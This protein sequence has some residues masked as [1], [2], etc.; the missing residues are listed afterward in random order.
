MSSTPSFDEL[1]LR[2]ELLRAVAEAGYTTPTPIQSQAIPTILQGL[3]VMGGAQTGTG[4]TAGFALPILQKLLP[5]ANASPSPAR[6]PVR[7]LIL[8]PTRELA[9]Q[10][11]EA[12]KTYGKYTGIRSTVVYGGVDIRQQLPIVRAGIEILVATPG[13]LLDHIEQK[14]VNLSQVEIFVLDEADRM[15]DMGFIPDI[16]RIMALLPATAKRQ[17]LLFSATF[18]NEIKKLAD[19]LLNAPTLI[20]VALR[21]TAAETVAQSVYKL[22]SD[23]KRALLTHIVTSRNLWQVLCFVRTKHGASRLARQLEKDGLKTTAIHGDKSQ[24]ARLEALDDF[25]A[26]KVQVMVATDVAARGLD[27]DDLPLVVNYEMPYVPEDYIHRIGRTGR[28]GAVGQAISLCAPDEEKLLAEIERMLKRTIPVAALDGFSPPR[29]APSAQRTTQRP[30][31]EVRETRGTKRAPHAATAGSHSNAHAAHSDSHAP[32]R[33]RAA[34]ADDRN[35]DQAPVSRAP[36]RTGAPSAPVLT[37][38]AG[39]PSLHRKHPI[40]ALLMKRS[41]REPE[42]V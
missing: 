26:A 35:P 39:R 29:D 10:V 1:G 36:N 20:E 31:R 14:S 4:K 30:T 18:S 27:I 17:N 12:V 41:V 16:K 7:A 24:A 19:Q 11:E 5:L 33:G 23:Q 28:A 22:A 40:P 3:D 34:D 37:G 9:I 38:T 32:R 2:P 13:R 6:H 42:K 8:T 25:K 15:L 21:N